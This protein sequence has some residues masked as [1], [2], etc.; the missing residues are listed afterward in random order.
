MNSYRGVSWEKGNS[1]YREASRTNDS[2]ELFLA[3]GLQKKVRK[4]SPDPRRSHH[5]RTQLLLV[6]E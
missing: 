1:S 6:G 4:V 3:R 5:H 2:G